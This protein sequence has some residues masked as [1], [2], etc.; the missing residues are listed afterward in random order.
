MYCGSCWERLPMNKRLKPAF[1]VISD[2]LGIVFRGPSWNHAFLEIRI[3][4]SAKQLE[5][6]REFLRGMHSFLSEGQSAGPTPV[7][8]VH[9]KPKKFSNGTTFK[10][11]K[12]MWATT[13]N[14]FFWTK[15]PWTP[16][17]TRKLSELSGTW[18]E[19]NPFAV[20]YRFFNIIFVSQGV[21]P[22]PGAAR[23]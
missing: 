4:T 15:T 7:T 23:A 8:C 11:K 20:R 21:Q 14:L 12:C 3:N 22:R 6:A 5:R 10:S 9:H 13:P 1:A 18:F 17:G 19:K 2:C 16:R